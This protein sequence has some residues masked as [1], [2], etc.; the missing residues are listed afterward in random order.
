MYNANIRIIEGKIPDITNLA[1]NITLNAK[2]NEVKINIPNTTNLTTTTALTAIK[3]KIANVSNLVKNTDLSTPKLVTLKINLLL[4]MIM[5]N[6]L[7]F[8]IIIS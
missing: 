5:M 1:T 3:N 4:I 6:I 7:L 2:L 8:W